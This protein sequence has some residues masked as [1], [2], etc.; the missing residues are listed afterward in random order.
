MSHSTNNNI[1]VVW[2]MWVDYLT[3][4]ATEIPWSQSVNI[5]P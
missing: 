1:Q 4:S 5:L 3:C 2:T